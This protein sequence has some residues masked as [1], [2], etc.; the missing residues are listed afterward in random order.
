MF[1]LDLRG[2]GPGT[3]LKRTVKEFLDDDMLTYAAALAYQVLFSL[4]PFILFLIALIGFLNVPDFF[5]WLRQQS[6]VLLPNQATQQVNRVIDQLQQ[7]Q[8]GLLSVGIVIAIWSAS[9]GF[10]AAMNALNTAYDVEEGRPA[11]KRFPLSIIYTIGLAIV[12][13]LA[14]GLMVIGPR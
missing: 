10:R 8:G 7:Q 1:S 11:W 6:A 3:L 9:A 5:A 4:F 14:A 2:L 12:L 13:L